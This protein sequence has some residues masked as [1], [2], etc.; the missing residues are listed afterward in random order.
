MFYRFSIKWGEK[1]FVYNKDIL[2]FLKKNKLIKDENK[3]ILI[4]GSG[5]DLNYFKVTP[6]PSVPD[7]LMIARLLSDKGIYEFVSAAEVIKSEHPDIRFKLVGW[8]DNANPT[9]ISKEELEEWIQ[10]GTIEYLGKLDDIRTAIT[11]SSVFVLP[12][13]HEGI[14]RSVLEAMSMGRPIITTDAYGCR[15]TVEDGKNGFLVPV[16]DSKSLATAM[17]HFIKKPNLILSM[18]KASRI[19]A[20]ERFDVRKVNKIILS[21]MKLL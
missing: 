8:I 15:E 3:A 20:E 11:E 16:R 14:P 21:T 4:N 19:M 1:V 7:F 10:R 9:A 12:S 6:L 18:G 2:S 13:Y 17:G 5:I